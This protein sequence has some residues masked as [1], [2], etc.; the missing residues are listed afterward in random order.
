MDDLPLLELF[1]R[2]REAGLQLGIDDYQAVLQALQAGYGLPNRAALARLCRTLWVRSA[3]D[4]RLFN[5]YFEL[6]IGSEEE[7]LLN[8]KQDAK[9]VINVRL[10]THAALAGVLIFGI[11]V[12]LRFDRPQNQTVT[13]SGS[14]P[15][16]TL[17]PTKAP[18]PTQ[19]PIP[20]PTAQIT[21]TQF[22]PPIWQNWYLLLILALSAGCVWLV[23]LLIQRR[24]RSNRHAEPSI[25]EPNPPV[26]SELLHEIEDEV[27]VAQAVR[28]VT[29]SHEEISRE[30]LLLSADYLPVTQRQMKQNWRYLRRLVR[31]GIPT[32]LDIDATINQLGRYGILL[33]PVLLPR[34][35]NRT[36]LLLLIDQEGSMVPFHSL[37]HR[38]ME[39]A[40]R[41]GRLGKFNIYYFHNCP[42]EY[43]YRD[44]YH[45]KA[46]LIKDVLNRLRQERTVVLIFSDGGAARGGLNSQ[47]IELTEAFLNQLKQ[48]V[49]Y[50]AWLNPMPRKRWSGTTAGEIAGLVPMFEV[51][52]QGLSGAIDTLRGRNK[53]LVELHRGGK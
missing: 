29:S 22:Q 46:E 32:E 21:Q 48:H 19:E 44:S 30:H 41:G 47:R 39:T 13:P 31:E 23:N 9:E 3:D 40:Q 45:Q 25:P 4:M 10:V 12:V 24:N 26:T 52:R 14:V 34:R 38:L 8:A 51:S 36:E 5:Y 33:E 35:V 15:I 20:T 37:S 17:V 50:I 11:A 43:I 16:P 18:V 6:L 49:R 2:L 28:Q 42:D 53:N 27:Q 7:D 1:T